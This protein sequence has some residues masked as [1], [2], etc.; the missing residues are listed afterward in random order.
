[1]KY[2]GT[3]R[4]LPELDEVT[5]DIPRDAKGDIAEGY[6]DLYIDCRN[7]NKIYMY[8]H[9]VNKRAI[10]S[11]Y[12]PSIGRGRNIKKALEEANVTYMNYMESDEEV[13]FNFKA[14]DIGIVADLLKAKTAGADISPF[15]VKNL[16]ADK[17]AEIPLE[18]NERYKKIASKV[19]KKDLLLIHKITTEFLNS[20]LQKKYKKYDK[21]FDYKTDMKKNMLARQV[22]EYIYLKEMWE[23]YLN[24]LS[25]EID[26]FYK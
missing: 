17:N 5:H 21:S 1:M 23:E 4:V 15:S 9:D 22:K 16:P 11:A 12:I 24:Y 6:D 7:H 19:Q 13:L 20:V 10:L 8:G 3:Y 14:K 2:K 18:E 25:K 26:K